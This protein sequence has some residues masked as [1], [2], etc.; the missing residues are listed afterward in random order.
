MV[1]E[2]KL[3]WWWMRGKRET[4]PTIWEDPDDLWERIHPIIPEDGS[5]QGDGAQA[6]STQANPG[7]HHIPDAHRLPVEPAAQGTGGRQHHPPDL[8]ALG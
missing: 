7:R 3:V 8:P 6:G 1:D 5:S 2:G 4:L